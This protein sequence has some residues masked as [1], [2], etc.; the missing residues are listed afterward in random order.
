MGEHSRE[1]IGGWL[2]LDEGEIAELVEAGVL[3]EPLA[4]AAAPA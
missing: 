4:P 1:V 3:H 2:G